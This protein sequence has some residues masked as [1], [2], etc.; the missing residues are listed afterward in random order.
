MKLGLYTDSLSDLP[1]E[2][3]LDWAACRGIEAIE[4]GTGNFS[5]A[6]HCDLERLQTDPTARRQFQ[7]VIRNRGL[8]LSAFNCNG[9][10]LDP[11]PSRRVASQHTFFKTIQVA[12]D[13]ELTTVI[14][15]SGCPGDLQGGT[16]P[17]WVTCAWQPEFVELQERQW[18]QE[19]EPFWRSAGAFASEHRVRIA[20]EMHPGQA[21]YNTRTLL[22]LRDI[23]GP[24]VGVNLDPSHLFWQGM[25]PLTV[26]RALGSQAIFHVHAK[27]CVTVQEEVALNGVLETRPFDGMRQRSWMFRAVGYGHP[28]AWW[29]EFARTL[30]STGFDGTVSI[31]HEDPLIE[32]RA[33][34]SK[35]IE[36][37]RP[38]LAAR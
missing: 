8:A 22:R 36:F 33:G 7:Q 24:A 11:D 38:M 32:A 14:A 4:L 17:N 23:A 29:Q 1:F 27:D 2:D 28:E 13:L 15:M 16:F 3:A 19:I 9:N 12:S 10:V 21:V 37:L 25:D 30:H 31:E 5:A 35:S 26:L 18:T 34:I 6:P 20:I